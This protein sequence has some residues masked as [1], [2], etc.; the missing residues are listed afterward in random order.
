MVGE[1]RSAISRIP[2]SSLPTPT[3][4]PTN[5]RAERAIRPAVKMLKGERKMLLL[6]LRARF[7]NLPSA[8]D[9]RVQAAGSELLDQ[10][11]TRVLGA[12]TL[13]DVFAN[14]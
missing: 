10:W 12:K 5:N 1:T 13:E 4:E 3:I 14:P 11:V 9:A 7:G 8:I 2:Q 6:M